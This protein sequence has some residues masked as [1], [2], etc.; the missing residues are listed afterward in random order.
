[1]SNLVA[2]F[3]LATVTGAC[4]GHPGAI[5]RCWTWRLNTVEGRAQ[6]LA[7]LADRLDQYLA[8]AKPCAVFY[9][10]PLPYSVGMRIGMRDDTLSFLRSTIAILETSTIRAG[11]PRLE[12]INVQD[13]RRHLVGRGRIPSGEGKAAVLRMCKVLRWPVS[14]LDES[15]AAAI[16]ALGCT[17]INPRMGYASTPLFSAAS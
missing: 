10:A 6:R 15:D 3:D 17:K 5:P 8:K 1:M 4:D 11:V 12:A 14:N 7:M 9:E 13:A 16:W 2:A